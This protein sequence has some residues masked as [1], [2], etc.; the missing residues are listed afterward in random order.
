M[1][2]IQSGTISDPCTL[3]AARR[4]VIESSMDETDTF[5]SWHR[6]AG[7]NDGYAFSWL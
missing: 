2:T 1:P 3:Y 4:S 6:S 5:S 7:V